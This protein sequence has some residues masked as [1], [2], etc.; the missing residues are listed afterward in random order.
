MTDRDAARSGQDHVRGDRTS[1]ASCRRAPLY[2]WAVDET[3]SAGVKHPGQVWRFTTAGGIGGVKGEYFT[4]MVPTGEPVLTRIDAA[5]DFAWGDGGEPGRTRSP[6]TSSPSGGPRISKSRSPTATPSSR[7]P[8][9]ASAC[10]S[11]TG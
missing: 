3:T 8:T 5:I 1:P 11:T 4:G 7:A 2:F 6:S 9:T 10:G